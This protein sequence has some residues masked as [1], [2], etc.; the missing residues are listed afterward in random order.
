MKRFGIIGDPVAHSM[1]PRLFTAA[2]HGLYPYDLIEGSNFEASWQRFLQEYDGINV[3]AP[4][5]ENAFAAVDNLSQEAE[6][7]GAVNLVVKA[8]DGTTTGYNSDYDGVRLALQEAGLETCRE[9]LVIGCGGAGKAAAAA[10]V[11]LGLSL[12]LINRDSAR[13]AALAKR[14]QDTAP[15][16]TLR[17]RHLS[18]DELEDAL[19]RA[20]LIVYAVP[21][22]L[23]GFPAEH[24]A[25][26]LN[27][28]KQRILL[29][30]NYRDPIFTTLPPC[31]RYISGRRWLLYQ[32]TE[33]YARF[34][35][36]APDADAILRQV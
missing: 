14:L 31:C 28:G 34:T 18:L 23:N 6:R 32:A 10:V 3:T 30:A 27:D 7:I 24:I 12:T 11:D 1:S 9:A 25:G 13:A 2:Y 5:K 26:L 33:G 15:D 20:D 8:T 17:V 36:K 35:G 16:G 19:L 4:F 21:G 22:P 29:E